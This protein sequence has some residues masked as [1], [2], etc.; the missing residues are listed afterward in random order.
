MLKKNEKY[1]LQFISAFVIVSHAFSEEEH[2]IRFFSSFQHKCECVH[3][4]NPKR[5]EDKRR[6]SEQ[7]KTKKKSHN[8]NKNKTVV[9]VRPGL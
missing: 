1:Q 4:A 6:A 8:K 2:S 9:D 7:S 3:C 5:D